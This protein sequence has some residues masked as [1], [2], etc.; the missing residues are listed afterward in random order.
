[1]INPYFLLK[2][3]AKI[4]FFLFQELK[5]LVGVKELNV[6]ATPCDV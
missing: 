2:L 1:M 3:S 4:H 6:G 5:E